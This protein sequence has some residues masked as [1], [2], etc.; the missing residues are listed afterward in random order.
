MNGVTATE[1]STGGHLPRKTTLLLDLPDELLVHIFLLTRDPPQH[2]GPYHPHP[3][4]PTN[5]TVSKI[6]VNKRIAALLH[7]HA[8]SSHH[9]DFGGGGKLG[10][11][12]LREEARRCT[13]Y[14]AL[15]FDYIESD[16]ALWLGAL[17]Q[18]SNLRGLALSLSVS[19]SDP[20]L[21]RCFQQLPNLEHLSLFWTRYL[22]ARSSLSLGSLPSLKRLDIDAS[23][24]AGEILDTAVS[25][26]R[27]TIHRVRGGMRALPLLWDIL[28]EVRFEDVNAAF[29]REF[30][31]ESF[32]PL[33]GGFQ[34]DLQKLPLQR[35]SFSL[36]DDAEAEE[37]TSLVFETVWEL[38]LVLSASNLRRID[39]SKLRSLDPP[40]PELRMPAVEQ[41][42]LS[43]ATSPQ[44]LVT[45]RSAADDYSALVLV[46]AA[47]PS[48]RHLELEGYRLWHVGAFPAYHASPRFADAPLTGVDLVAQVVYFRLALW[49]KGACWTRRGV[50]V[51]FE[52]E[53]WSRF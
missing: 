9:M 17:T 29:A 10:R 13:L 21:K 25:V 53:R 22:P 5:L 23:L 2:A 47:F 20:D 45:G 38:L 6:L 16:S 48:L 32:M 51:D 39:L 31:F 43:A 37:E 12:L 36:R 46:L 28:E 49:N 30:L 14:L 44:H 19:I 18:L 1:G 3:P 40:P 8:I 33:L 42:S 34:R 26:R 11:I 50:E 24:A 35:I 27:L 15:D 52:V 4:H 41:L 7:R